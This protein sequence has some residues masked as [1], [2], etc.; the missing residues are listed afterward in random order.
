MNGFLIIL[1]IYGPIALTT[2]L[3]ATLPKILPKSKFLKQFAAD[4]N[5]L[6]WFFCIHSTVCLI[7]ALLCDLFLN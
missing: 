4:G 7:I 3:L 2:F 1:I 5:F 6:C